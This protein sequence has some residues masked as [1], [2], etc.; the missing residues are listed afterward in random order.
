MAGGI[1]Y[2]RL[3]WYVHKA[4]SALGGE[5]CLEPS[6]NGPPVPPQLPLT[7]AVGFWSI[8]MRIC[9]IIMVIFRGHW[10]VNLTSDKFVW[11]GGIV[12]FVWDC[13]LLTG[14]G[15]IFEGL[16]ALWMGGFW[17]P[18]IERGIHSRKQ[19]PIQTTTLCQSAT[20]HGPHHTHRRSDRYTV[21]YLKCDA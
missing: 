1:V 20:R 12:P 15:D 19:N 21:T 5:R 2:L 8:S 16:V 11:F 18:K 3:K 4:R 10:K 7:R 14:A 9:K 6:L 13:F 17:P